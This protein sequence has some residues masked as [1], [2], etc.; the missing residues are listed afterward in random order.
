[1]KALSIHC[2]HRKMFDANS[3]QTKNERLDKNFISLAHNSCM[4]IE[5]SNETE[6]NRRTLC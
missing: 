5:M 4:K 6:K 3:K 2:E 1:M